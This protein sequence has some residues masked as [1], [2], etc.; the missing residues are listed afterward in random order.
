MQPLGED[1]PDRIGPYLLVSRL[2]AG[3]MG[4]AYL[5][6]SPGGR[7][8]AVKVVRA[9]LAEDRGFR[10][11]FRREVQ[12]CRAVSGAFTTPVV[13]A[14]PDAPN[15]WLAT[16]YVPGPSLQEAV[17]AHGRLDEQDVRTLAS[18]LAEALVAIH[19]AGLVH[20][21]LKPGNVLLAEDGPRVI[22]FGISRAMDGTAL[23]GTGTVMGSV[24]YM[25]PEQVASTRDVG[26]AGDVF[27][28]GATL[29]FASTGRG[30]FGSGSPAAV[31]Y[32]VVNGPP[33]LD[34]VPEGL[35]PLVTACL[36]KDAARRPA[37]GDIVGALG[38]AGSWPPPVLRA[39]LQ[40]RI[41]EAAALAAAPPDAGPNG[42]RPGDRGDPAF[43][44]RPAALSG[45]GRPPSRRRVLGLAAGVIG[46]LAGLAGAAAWAADGGSGR[47]RPTGTARGTGAARG[48][49]GPSLQAGPQ[50]TG[51]AQ[52]AG[53]LP[54]W[55]F[56]AP[57]LDAHP[58]MRAFGG[59]LVIDAR[60]AGVYGVDVTRGSRQWFLPPR[61]KMGSWVVTAAP[62]HFVDG[63]AG[64]YC[65]LT[66]GMHSAT[67]LL[68]IDM[69]NGDLRTVGTISRAPEMPGS[70]LAMSGTVVL[71]G[72]AVA[73]RSM[74][75]A[76]D[77]RSRRRLW[78]RPAA[79][80]G[81]VAAAADEHGFYVM[82]GPAGGGLL[83][84]DAR[85]GRVRWRTSLTGGVFTVG[86]TVVVLSG[87]PAPGSPSRGEMVGLSAVDGRPRWQMVTG[88]R[89]QVA[90]SATRIHLIS[91]D[92]KVQCVDPGTSDVS[93]TAQ[94]T[95]KAATGDAPR[96]IAAS[97]KLVAAVFETPNSSGLRAFD[98]VD[99]S[100]SWTYTVPAV[101]AAPSSFCVVDN[102]VC[103]LT[104]AG[105]GI[106]GFVG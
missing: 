77:V 60:G 93:W 29:A 14:D 90:V 44:P 20:R 76:Y 97:D 82:E 43:P 101:S 9:E 86:G 54:S 62:S 88:P 27:A 18:G 40:R 32:R 78:T 28:L 75:A 30:P 91:G 85:S 56:T 94:G 50:A 74:V 31:L 79:A 61:T 13:A 55:T 98:P 52:P 7:L 96:M 66:G 34:G 4:V 3:G 41:G 11:R 68:S 39:E 49:A 100:A 95:G 17:A 83:A 58:D 19:R 102:V 37:P 36:E 38:A 71:F 23:T 16:T 92:Y 35:L 5:A 72:I 65:S 81:Q 26:P 106:S 99:G 48:T 80:G 10:A 105:A 15:P 53:P 42:R 67:E 33:R 2:G 84:L 1:D 21:D 69:Q 73:G 8:T 51:P 87:T 12:A 63:A 22:D 70:L 6:S 104:G 25:A 64:P 46:G 59:T 24:G 47:P 57:G 103:L 45:A 89:P